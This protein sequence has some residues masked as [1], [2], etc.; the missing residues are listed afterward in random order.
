MSNTVTRKKGSGLLNSYM[1]EEEIALIQP[2]TNKKGSGLI[3]TRKNSGSAGEFLG[4]QFVTGLTGVF[5]NTGRWLTGTFYDIAGD[6]RMA[7]YTFKSRTWSEKTAQASREK[8]NP[9]GFMSFAGDV[10][11]GLGQSSAF[12][13][14]LTGVPIGTVAFAGGAI[15]GATADAVRTTGEAGLK[16]Y[17]YGAISGGI[18][19]GLEA[20]TGFGG[21]KIATAAAKGAKSV[22]WKIA[23]QATRN[24]VVKGM[25]SSAGGEFVEEFLSAILDPVVRR[26][27]GV[28]KNATVNWGEALYAGMTGFASGGIMGTATS[29][30][31]NAF[32]FAAGKKAQ[33]RGNESYIINTARNISDSFKAENGTVKLLNDSIYNLKASLRAY[34][35]AKNNT[36]KTMLVG[37]MWDSIARLEAADGVQ[38]MYERIMS[39]AT[40]ENAKAASALLGKT[41]TLADLKANKDGVAEQY[42]INAWATDFL[43]QAEE[44]ESADMRIQ[45]V[46][47]SNTEKQIT[48][49]LQNELNALQLGGESVYSTEDRRIAVY[50]R[51]DG[52]YNVAVQR[53]GDSEWFYT[54]GVSSDEASRAV[55]AVA[56]N[57]AQN[58][59]HSNVYNTAYSEQDLTITPQA[60]SSAQAS[61]P[62]TNYSLPNSNLDNERQ[63]GYNE[64]KN[65]NIGDNKNG[66]NT[67]VL[68]GRVLSAANRS[69]ND[70]R[71]QSQSTEEI[72]E[73]LEK[74]EN[75][76]RR[77]EK[78]RLG[79]SGF[80]K[81][82]S[83]TPLANRSGSLLRGLRHKVLSGKDVFGRTVPSNVA[84]K[85]ANTIFKDENGN[86]L[87]VYHWTQAFFDKFANGDIG[88]HFGTVDSAYHRAYEVREDN[89]AKT[90][91]DVESSIFKESYANITNPVFFE[92]DAGTWY[93]YTAALL[94]KD[95]NVF[96]ESDVERIEALEGAF[97]V[98]YNS[99]ASQEIRRTLKEY[100]YDGIIYKNETEEDYSVIALYP[101]Q[102]YTVA[103]NGIDISHDTASD[104]ENLLLNAQKDVK[105]GNTPADNKT[106]N[107][108]EKSSESKKE[109]PANNAGVTKLS[110]SEEKEGSPGVDEASTAD[111]SRA[112]STAKE[113]TE[114]RRYY[115]DFDLL[116]PG[117]RA[118]IIRL[119]RTADK[120]KVSA[121][122]KRF[123]ANVIAKRDIDIVFSDKITA[124]GLHN[125]NAKG[126][127][128]IV[129]NPKKATQSRT[130]EK[131]VLHEVFHDI[132]LTREGKKLISEL[133]GRSDFDTVRRDYNKRYREAFG[134]SLK[135]EQLDEE[136]AADLLASLLGN[137]R[138]IKRLATEKPNIVVRA[139]HSITDLFTY[140]KDKNLA[141]LRT[142]RKLLRMYDKAIEESGVAVSNAK[143][144][145]S[146]GVTDDNKPVVVVNDDILRNTTNKDEEIAA[147]KSALSK[148]KKVPI[149]KQTILITRDS[150]NEI[151]RSKNTET[152]RKKNRTLYEDKMRVM[153]HPVDIILAT[154]DYINEAP[155]HLRK[156]DIVDFARGM[157]LLQVQG[158]QYSAEAVYGY[159]KNGTCRLHDIVQITPTNFTIKKSNYSLSLDHH[160]VEYRRNESFDTNSISQNSEKSTPSGKKSLS[161]AENNADEIFAPTNMAQMSHNQRRAIK[162]GKTTASWMSSALLREVAS[163]D[164][165]AQQVFDSKMVE[166]F[167]EGHVNR[168]E[169]WAWFKERR[170]EIE[171]IQSRHPENLSEADRIF[172]EK[173]ARAEDIK[174]KLDKNLFTP[175]QIEAQTKELDQLMLELADNER[176][177]IRR[178][179][180]ILHISYL[181]SKM[182]ELTRAKFAEKDLR[183]D[184][185]AMLKGF[186]RSIIGHD[187]FSAKRAL[188]LTAKIYL[189]SM[190]HDEQLVTVSHNND[191]EVTERLFTA[192]IRDSMELLLSRVFGKRANG[193]K[194]TLEQLKELD[195]ES[196]SLAEISEWTTITSQE[197]TAHQSEEGYGRIDKALYAP[198]GKEMAPGTPLRL[199]PEEL[200]A[201]YRIGQYILTLH[202]SWNKVNLWDG[203]Y[204]DVADYAK[205]GCRILNNTASMNGSD[206][207]VS[208]IMSVFAKIHLGNSDPRGVFRLLDNFDENG[209]LTK[210]YEAFAEGEAARDKQ[211]IDFNKPFDDFF[212]EHKKYSDRLMTEYVE[213]RGEKIRLGEAIYLHELLKRR[214]AKLS[215][216]TSEI[217]Y[218]TKGKEQ[219]SLKPLHD[220]KKYFPDNEKHRK[221]SETIGLDYEAMNWT[222]INAD[223]LAEQEKLKKLFSAEDLEYCKLV[224][225]YFDVE[226]RACKIEADMKFVG[227]T[228]TVDGFYIPK[229]VHGDAVTTSIQDS[230]SMMR[231]FISND[232]PTFAK[233]VSDNVKMLDLFNVEQIRQKHSHDLATYMHVYMPIKAFDL[234]YN[235][236]TAESGHAHDSI[237]QR[238]RGIWQGSHK[239]ITELYQQVQG[240]DPSA[241]DDASRAVRFLR[242]NFTRYVLGLKFTSAAKQLSAIPQML[243]VVNARAIAYGMAHI[244]SKP[245]YEDMVKYSGDAAARFYNNTLVRSEAVIGDKFNRGFDRVAFFLLETAD[246]YV[247][248]VGW[249][250]AQYEAQQKQGFDI[251][252]EENKK[253]AGV[254]LNRIIRETQANSS[255]SERSAYQ[256]SGNEV[257][258]TLMMFK[259]D[260]V[261][262]YSR[263]AEGV[264]RLIVT[265]KKMNA[266]TATKDDV[267]YARHAL[268]CASVGLLL[269]LSLTVAISQICK[270]LF[271]KER[272]DKDGNEISIMRDTIEEFGA[273]A[274]SLLPLTGD[275]YEYLVSGYEIEDNTFSMINS[276]LNSFTT[277]IDTAG[278][279]LGGEAYSEAKMAR[280][281][282]NVAYTVGEFTGMPVSTVMDY[283]NA[284]V[285]RVSPEA[286]YKSQNLFYPYSSADVAK[287]LDKSD[288][289]TAVA[290]TECLY[291]SAGG[292]SYGRQKTVRE[293][294]RL[295]KLGHTDVLPRAA[296]TSITVNG[297]KKT[298]SKSEYNKYKSIYS[299]AYREIY[300]LTKMPEWELIDDDT[301]ASLIGKVYD[302]YRNQAKVSVSSDVSYSKIN[303]LAVQY[304]YIS[305]DKLIMALSVAEILDSQGEKTSEN[306]LEYLLSAGYTQKEAEAS[307][308][309]I[310]YSSKGLKSKYPEMFEKNK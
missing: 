30:T 162:G 92:A 42:A 253:A 120:F 163:P 173:Y 180:A 67:G 186:T 235:Y 34:D 14:N 152:L 271:K 259:S 53:K 10:S 158:R 33:A 50:R 196:P 26:A 69:R 297:E 124:E 310:G 40:E 183:Q 75:N 306:I 145:F 288:T 205:Q 66:Q 213:Y 164:Y 189:F 203:E 128:I 121:M 304:K 255:A 86:L 78:T 8:Y 174:I 278:M 93:S 83:S 107:T 28:D 181:V 140:A 82:H 73:L 157:I 63:S 119:I 238:L 39:T 195:L 72:F 283:V 133:K 17:A 296:S 122:I 135:G 276:A 171:K 89:Y 23:G 109:T 3:S 298:L 246:K 254:I 292:T 247:I 258:R 290:I 256:R 49:N 265:T 126:E 115:K 48:P 70:I 294:L 216:L 184:V 1:T 143:E 308:I 211:K 116:A 169:L 38:V 117:T 106:Q 239:Y 244:P 54:K 291:D 182:R 172:L 108:A 219:S 237:K 32:H 13:L 87:S 197:K 232:K 24:G 250:A 166:S 56:Q 217:Y 29:A 155:K 9:G 190:Q 35:K 132:A 192:E 81:K 112:P 27:T 275:I 25:L 206:G 156:D 263:F 79:S 300:N 202:S 201:L 97:K 96:S 37:E 46:I 233:H 168:E 303:K 224:E 2:Q 84:K 280:N 268:A 44:A 102:I 111:D 62:G 137:E 274:T 134:R 222:A 299:K 58:T 269:S 15:G 227:V 193:Q 284:I 286:Y 243:N 154:T 129:I 262:N 198:D 207:V 77:N 199:T 147:V 161:P 127:R 71:K 242:K 159:A 100:G 188:V 153:N 65:D 90:G 245:V 57:T 104:A 226:A 249:Q 18:E 103:E 178:R 301:K 229:R 252:T 59:V 19:F 241:N 125:T 6:D 295:Y 113:Q 36:R 91:K 165:V 31:V 105:T 43:S 223:A 4:T 21:T 221:S 194:L 261:K 12:L 5:E 123:A 130:V 260:S 150:A 114:A 191:G 302:A 176:D 200:V 51:K 160:T 99:A 240:H 251:G 74:R 285:S 177:N 248:E 148:F 214:D 209:V 230:K 101:D 41:V 64:N 142:M 61:S 139:W 151:T 76:L 68:E 60:S 187:I 85:F 136:A 185:N 210:L 167:V 20:L 293:L 16:E 141:E 208:K 215:L 236:N 234:V 175:S 270:S 220:I 45:S 55:M 264:A 287:E 146:I 149:H 22:G 212:A 170:A 266:G 289:K 11:S 305:L 7:D 231:D 47:D 267:D 218:H 131:I 88:F 277:L 272:R 204:I 281:L 257:M 118:K 98:D 110:V 307:L 95:A 273:Q 309:A 138:W 225:N 94:L 279:A 179:K 52:A 80:L 144:N 282:R 228:S